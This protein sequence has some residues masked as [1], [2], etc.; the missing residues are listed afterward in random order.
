MIYPS[1]GISRSSTWVFS[2]TWHAPAG[3]F[4]GRIKVIGFS[5]ERVGRFRTNAPSRSG[6]MTPRPRISFRGLVGIIGVAGAVQDEDA[7]QE[8][9]P[10]LE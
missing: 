6:G 8:P 1:G 7:R 3:I 5:R 9:P 2:Q 4:A 10:K